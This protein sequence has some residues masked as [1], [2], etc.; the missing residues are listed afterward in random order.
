[1]N[2]SACATTSGQKRSKSSSNAAGS[3]A[4]TSAADASGHCRRA[5]GQP[6]ADA[7]QRLAD[8]AEVAVG[9][10]PVFRRIRSNAFAH[11]AG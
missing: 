11:P 1:M 7:F 5:R 10:Q 8:F 3:R 2:A 4:K 6:A 9:H